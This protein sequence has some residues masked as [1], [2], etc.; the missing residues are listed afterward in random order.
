MP[1]KLHQNCRQRLVKAIADGLPGT[2]FRS[3]DALVWESSVGLIDIDAILPKNVGEIGLVGVF[4]DQPLLS[5]ILEQIS[6]EVSKNSWDESG[7]EFDIT[8]LPDYS[9]TTEAANRLVTVFETLPWE[10]ELFIETPLSIDFA[11]A[12]GEEPFALRT[13]SAGR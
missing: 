1:L 3:G 5:F 13:G 4:P 12:L 8:Q 7:P 10:Y 2:K 9:N 11:S 6:D